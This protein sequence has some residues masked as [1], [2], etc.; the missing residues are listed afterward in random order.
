V[1]SSPVTIAFRPGVD[2]MR[3]IPST[4]P[5]TVDRAGAIAGRRTLSGLARRAAA[6]CAKPTA[7]VDIKPPLRI[8]TGTSQL[9]GPVKYSSASLG[10]RPGDGPPGTCT[11]SLCVVSTAF[12]P[13]QVLPMTA[14]SALVRLSSGECRLNSMTKLL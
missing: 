13:R 2:W 1:A 8:P 4:T 3:S 9:G 14:V 5:A 12:Q 6:I 11:Y 7:G 10:A